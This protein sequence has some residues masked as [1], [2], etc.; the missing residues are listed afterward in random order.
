MLWTIPNYNGIF[1][2]GGWYLCWIMML[3]NTL[4]YKMNQLLY[5]WFIENNSQLKIFIQ[6]NYLSVRNH[7]SIHSLNT[8]KE[9]SKWSGVW[10]CNNKT[11]SFEINRV[12]NISENIT[13]NIAVMDR[14]ILLFHLEG[15]GDGSVEK[16]VCP[17]A[18]PSPF[19]DKFRN[20][21]NIK[22]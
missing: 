19:S 8:G 12:L 4:D 20:E 1:A 10:K 7:L 17:G 18:F 15:T 14:N 16:R 22:H 3:R 9:R 6:V 5:M 21:T 13:C 11:A 2:S